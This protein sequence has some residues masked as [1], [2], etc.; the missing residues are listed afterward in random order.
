ML[1][2]K[3]KINARKV[4][5]CES[6]RIKQELNKISSEIIDAKVTKEKLEQGKTK[7]EEFKCKANEHRE[8]I[9]RSLL[10]K[11]QQ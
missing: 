11:S 8:K 6:I 2:S 4:S 9:I 7:W 3:S 5:L 1:E 10:I